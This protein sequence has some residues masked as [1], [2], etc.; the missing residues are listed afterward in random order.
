MGKDQ[1]PPQRR[2]SKWPRLCLPTDLP[3]LLPTVE[4]PLQSPSGSEEAPSQV[5]QES[6]AQTVQS[7]ALVE[8]VHQGVVSPEAAVVWACLVYLSACH[9]LGAAVKLRSPTSSLEF[10][11]QPTSFKDELE[12]CA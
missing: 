11:D 8:A 5:S 3:L 2:S 9:T 7:E 10:G 4:V 12:P 6:V 1:V